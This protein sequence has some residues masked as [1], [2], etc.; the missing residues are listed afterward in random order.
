M[1]DNARVS[2]CSLLCYWLVID[3]PCVEASLFGTC[4]SRTTSASH[5]EFT[6]TQQLVCAR[7]RSHPTVGRPDQSPCATRSNC[8]AG[9]VTL[10][11][12]RRNSGETAH[13]LRKRTDLG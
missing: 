1:P 9:V 11:C 10:K 5:A 8:C 2:G 3:H 6:G 4:P 13:L 7:Q 12:S